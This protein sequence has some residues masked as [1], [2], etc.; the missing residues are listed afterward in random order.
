MY[1]TLSQP[2]R[3]ALTAALLVSVAATPIPGNDSDVAT[4]RVPDGSILTLLHDQPMRLFLQARR[5]V[6]RVAGAA[7]SNVNVVVQ[8]NVD[9]CK[10]VRTTRA[11][12]AFPATS[13]PD[14]IAYTLVTGGTWQP[15]RVMAVDWSTG[16]VTVETPNNAGKVRVY[17]TFGDGE[18]SIRA[19]RPF[20][21]SGGY[22]QLYRTSARSLH[23]TDQTDRDAAPF[24]ARTP[25]P[26][27]QN[28]TLSLAVR[29]SSAVFMDGLAR[30]EV[31]IPATET[32]VQVTNAVMLAEL[33]E[34]QLK[35]V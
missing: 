32:A 17:Y 15:A 22:I 18:I 24:A 29:A 14:V 4:F 16:A 23:E 8:V 3:M 10:L 20:G 9:G 6:G 31:S 33:A 26:I 34:R 1:T 7:G 13:H 5:E 28:F 2:R 12:R 30:H 11:D 27:P 21:S 35:G 25:Q 19:G